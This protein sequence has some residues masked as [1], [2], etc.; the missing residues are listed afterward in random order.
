MSQTGEV[1]KTFEAF[2][3]RLHEERIYVEIARCASNHGVPLQTL[4]GRSRPPR[5]VRARHEAFLFLKD[6]GWSF[7]EIGALFDRDHTSVLTGCHRTS[8]LPAT[9]TRIA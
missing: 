5:V 9:R 1:P 7:P 3:R 4:W 6:S 8:Q 2:I